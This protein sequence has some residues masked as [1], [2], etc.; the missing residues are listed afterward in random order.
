MAKAPIRSVDMIK[1]LLN[2]SLDSDLQAQLEFEDA[3]QGLA[4]STA[5]MME[6]VISFFKNEI[7]ISRANRG[8]ER[9]E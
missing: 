7:L 5:D 2:R 6:G 8:P 1:R 3:F 4:T 9:E